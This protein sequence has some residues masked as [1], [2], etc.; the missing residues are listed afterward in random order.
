MASVAWS[1]SRPSNPMVLVLNTTVELTRETIKTCPPSRPP[2][3][4]DRLFEVPGI[5]SIDLHRYR[6]RLNIAPGA[7]RDLIITQVCS[8]SPKGN[9]AGS[10]GSKP[11]TSKMKTMSPSMFN[12]TTGHGS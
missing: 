4:L 10:V 6:A 8:G 11:F 5:R 2:R 9:L 1:I 7:D 12:R 3:P